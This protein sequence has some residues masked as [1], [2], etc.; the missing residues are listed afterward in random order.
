MRQ[1]VYRVHLGTNDLAFCVDLLDAAESNIKP[2]DELQLGK[3]Y[4]SCSHK[5]AEHKSGAVANDCRH[6]FVGVARR[7]VVLPSENCLKN[8]KS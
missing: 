4:Q 2:R 5:S 8:S 7:M 3:I 1:G 6:G